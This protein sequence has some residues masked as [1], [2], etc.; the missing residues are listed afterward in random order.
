GDGDDPNAPPPSRRLTFSIPELV[1]LV[2][3]QNDWLTSPK[4]REAVEAA[5]RDAE[6][7]VGEAPESEELRKEVERA[8]AARDNLALWRRIQFWCFAAMMVGFAAKV[9]LFPVPTWLPLAHV[10]AP[11]AGSVLLA[12]VLL[13]LGTYGFLRL[14]LPV[15]PDACVTFGAPLIGG[16]A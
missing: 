16:L 8:R 1:K 9:P 5:V 7:K 12:G 3:Q 15:V 2:R 14:C 11:T 4:T 6:K 10:E 13:K